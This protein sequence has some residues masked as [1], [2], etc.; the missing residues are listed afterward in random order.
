[1]H[2]LPV[3]ETDGNAF[4]KIGN[5]MAKNMNLSAFLNAFASY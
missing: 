3:S 2:M 1:M 5:R 4:C